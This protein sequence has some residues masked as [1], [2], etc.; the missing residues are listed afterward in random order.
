[1]DVVR[2]S[3]WI[4]IL[5]LP[6]AA[7]ARVWQESDFPARP[8]IAYPFNPSPHLAEAAT[9][10]GASHPYTFRNGDT[11]YDVARHLGLGINEVRDA[12]PEMDVWL[13]PE[14]QRV[15][16]PTW[17]ILPESDYKG[18]VVNIPEMRLYYFPPTKD[19]P[20]VITYAVGLGRDEW[21]T[22]TGRFKVS[23]KTVNPTWVIPDSIREERMREKGRFEK[24]IPGGHPENPLGRYRM[25]LTLPLYGIH[26]TNIAWGVGMQV[27]HGCIRLYPEDID[28]LFPIVPVGSP[29][30][31]VYQAVK[32]GVRSGRIYA[33]VHRDIYDS[34]YDYWNEARAVLA[35]KGWEDYVDW[36]RLAEAIDRKSGVPTWIS[37]AGPMPEAE[38]ENVSEA[39]LRPEGAPASVAQ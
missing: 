23:E 9:V 27:S 15:P 24:L 39:H 6:L 18:V 13:P 31:F 10:V 28:R 5:L 26:G 35:E 2:K 29:G 36:G 34:G 12:L 37:L 1:M 16:F 22:P 17:W 7:D 32:I 21:Q 8:V 14:G 25:R 3:L 30:E 4:V 38:E 33:E 11:L 19:P 20:T